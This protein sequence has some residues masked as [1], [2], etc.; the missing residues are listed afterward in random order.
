MGDDGGGAL[1]LQIKHCGGVALAWVWSSKRQLLAY[2]QTCDALILTR[3]RGGERAAWVLPLR[4]D[5]GLAA[6]LEA[7]LSGSPRLDFSTAEHAA[8]AL[9]EPCVH[10]RAAAW[11][12][13]PRAA[14]PQA[15]GAQR[16]A[17]GGLPAAALP[18]PCGAPRGR[19]EARAALD[20]PER[21]APGGSG[22]ARACVRGVRSVRSVRRVP[23]WTYVRRIPTWSAPT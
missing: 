21:R 6:E 17:G 3:T 11:G 2:A 18:A 20:S 10:G 13:P 14:L 19:P 22:G 7:R 15:W 5:L 23:T 12:A 1:A 9:G 4:A 8:A 16:A